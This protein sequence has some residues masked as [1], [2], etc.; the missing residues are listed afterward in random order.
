MSAAM[1]NINPLTALRSLK[2]APLSCLVALMFA[3]QP[4]GKEW[5]ARVT[6]YSDKPV[7]AAMDYLL[8]MGFVTNAA[9]TESWELHSQIRQLMIGNPELLLESSRNNSDSEP[10]TTALNTD[11]NINQEKAVVVN[12]VEASDQEE[13]VTSDFDESL[14]IIKSAGIGEPMAS[15]LARMHH[16]NPYYLIGHVLQAQRDEINIRLLIH[17]LRSRD[18]APRLNQNYHLVGCKC[19]QCFHFIYNHDRGLLKINDFNY[20]EYKQAICEV[21]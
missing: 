6:G 7:S 2:G 13:I 20:N 4:V 18:P 17:R 16:I 19:N 1:S 14:E 11:S 21:E 12:A 15:R 10:T 9:R 8:E 3:N 5:L